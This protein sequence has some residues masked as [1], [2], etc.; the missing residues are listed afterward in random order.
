MRWLKSLCES[1][2]LI[3]Q[4]DGVFYI[5]VTSINMDISLEKEQIIAAILRSIEI[6]K[7]QECDPPYL[8]YLLTSKAAR[9]VQRKGI[10]DVK[11]R[12]QKP[13]PS[14]FKDNL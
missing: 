11:I 8:V 1:L 7:E 9:A 4:Y 6:F 14:H 10:P 3:I 13:I 2:M 5:G 12:L